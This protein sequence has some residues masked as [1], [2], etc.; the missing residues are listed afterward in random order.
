MR[1]RE[2]LKEARQLKLI[3]EYQLARALEAPVFLWADDHKTMTDDEVAFVTEDIMECTNFP[4]GRTGVFP[5]MVPF[6]VFRISYT[7]ED[8][9]EQWWINKTDALC[10]RMDNGYSDARCRLLSLHHCIR[11]KP[12]IDLWV[13]VNG[14]ILENGKAGNFK[15]QSSEEDLKRLANA[16]ME[17][18]GYFLLDVMSPKNVTVKVTPKSG[19]SVQWVLAHTHYLVLDQKE[20]KEC[21]ERKSGPTDEEIIRAAHRRRAHF[22]KLVSERFTNKRGMKVPVREAWIGPKEW[23]GTDKKIYQVFPN[24]INDQNLFNDES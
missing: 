7:K 17:W 13:M 11:G 6:D 3:T 12:Q 21:R 14:K 16:P 19:R 24:R 4:D 18:L 1:Q 2:V 23:V 22:R 15:L 5:K 20:A 10:L 9:F 8:I